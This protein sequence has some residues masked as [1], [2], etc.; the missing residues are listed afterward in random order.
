M[1]LKQ[2]KK[3]NEKKESAKPL[4][5]IIIIIFII[6]VILLPLSLLQ[7]FDF[8]SLSKLGYLG[9]FLINFITSATVII[10]IPGAASAFVGGIVLNP[11]LVGIAA[12]IGATIGELSGYFAGYGGRRLIKKYEKSNNLLSKLEYLF[13]QN[14]FA[15]ILVCAA[16]PFPFFDFIGILSGAFKYPI[17]KFITAILIGRVSRDIIFAWSGG[18]IF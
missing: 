1:K 18:K 17:W 6:L 7:D 9:I 13:H 11:V 14:G 15:T 16:L 8:R 3:N 2:N 12:G 10:P 5:G 4:W